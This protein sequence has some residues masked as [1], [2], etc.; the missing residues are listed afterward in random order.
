MVEMIAFRL[1]AS[2]LLLAAGIAL[3]MLPSLAPAQQSNL[4]VFGAAGGAPDNEGS[5]LH[6]GGGGE[7]VAARLIG[8]GGELG[9]LTRTGSFRDTLGVL[10]INGYGHIPLKGR[11]DPYVTGGYSMFFRSG[12]A[13]GGNFGVGANLPLLAKL[14]LKFE[15]RDH[16]ISSGGRKNHWWEGRVGVTF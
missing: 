14:G 15:F 9:A 5:T 7:F 6:I 12:T 10:S 4:Y 8:V 3:L 16:V 13:S 1:C 11:L 2:N